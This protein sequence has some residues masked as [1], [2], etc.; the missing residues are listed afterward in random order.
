MVRATR[1]RD[2][3]NPDGGLVGADLYE[4][5]GDPQGALSSMRSNKASRSSGSP[6]DVYNQ[7]LLSHLVSVKDSSVTAG[8]LAVKLEEFD[9][10]QQ[11]A[12]NDKRNAPPSARK[13]KRRDWILAYN[14]ALA[15]HAAGN[16]KGSIELCLEKLKPVILNSQNVSE[17]LINVYSHMA[18][19]FLEGI[20][21]SSVGC[22]EGIEQV[23]REVTSSRIVAWLDTLDLEKEPQVK[24][25]LA[26][27]KSRL[28]FQERDGSGRIVD[29]K[30]RSA[31][32]ELK[33]AM[34]IFQHKLKTSSGDLAS[35]DSSFSEENIQSSGSPSQQQAPMSRILQ[36]QNQAALNLKANTEQLKGNIKKSLI[37]CGEA[38]AAVSEEENSS[39]AALH[40]SNLANI[41]ETN[42]RRHL[43]LHMMGKALRSNPPSAPFDPDGTAKPDQ[44]L[45]ILYNASIASAQAQN[46]VAAYECM[47]TCVRH[48]GVMSKRPRCW[49]RLAEACIGAQIVTLS[50]LQMLHVSVL[51]LC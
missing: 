12:A 29:Q 6:N 19:L 39:Y 37:L 21:T 34:E 25:L 32:K 43:A 38:Q 17:D 5:L 47:A 40:A 4:V 11:T 20:I 1:G 14:R 27:Y 46:Y 45:K 22:H 15:L 36:R 33:Q 44:T 31:R 18:F 10:Q 49:L 7:L 48:S 13:R 30:I 16:A 8:D 9:T 42:G 35:V 3:A 2:V 24:F 28:E 51:L 23:D 26:L 41:Y 50:D